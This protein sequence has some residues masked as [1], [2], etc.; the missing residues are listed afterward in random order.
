MKIIKVSG[1][2]LLLLLF[3][4]A[5]ADELRGNLLHSC[6]DLNVVLPSVS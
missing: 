3:T 5:D 6:Y 4:I 2:V 1:V